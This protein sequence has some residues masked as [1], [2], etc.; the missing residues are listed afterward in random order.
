MRQ[1]KNFE[2]KNKY[3]CRVLHFITDI[4]IPFKTE[5][6]INFDI[7]FDLKKEKNSSS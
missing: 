4:R 6:N 3:L 2:D 7:V 1:T 5:K